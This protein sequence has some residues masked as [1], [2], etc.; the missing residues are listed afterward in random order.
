VTRRNNIVYTCADA[1]QDNE[2]FGKNNRLQLYLPMSTPKKRAKRTTG[3]NGAKPAPS[4]PAAKAAKSVRKGKP[5]KAGKPPEGIGT[6]RYRVI[7]ARLSRAYKKWVKEM[8]GKKKPKAPAGFR[9]TEDDEG[10]WIYHPDTGETVAE[11]LPYTIQDGD[12]ITCYDPDPASDPEPDIVEFE[13]E[14]TETGEIVVDYDCGGT[15]DS[16]EIDYSVLDVFEEDYDPASE[17]PYECNDS[18][19]S[20]GING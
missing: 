8:Y 17:V 4:K 11:P 15:N 16:L 2:L 19:G 10:I 9:I 3:K 6:G 20:F 12:V 5:A 18:T 13:V 14:D 1:V 7:S